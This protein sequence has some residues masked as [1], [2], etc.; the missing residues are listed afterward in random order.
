MDT[1]TPEGQEAE[2]PNYSLIASE[3]FGNDFKGEIKEQPANEQPAEPA[4]EPVEAE[5]EQPAE[6]VKESPVEAQEA[7]EEGETPISSFDE[8][9]ESQGWD[10]EWANSLEF[11]QKVDGETRLVTLKDLIATNQTLSAAEKRLEDAKEKAKTQYQQLAETQEKV[12]ETF[13]VAYAVLENQKKAIDEEAAKVD[14]ASLR[15]QDPGEASFKK[16]EF[17][18]RREAVEAEIGKLSTQYQEYVADQQQKSQAALQEH[19]QKEQ[20]ALLE[21]LPEWK[22]P[23]KAKAGHKEV[24]DYLSSQGFT[25]EEIAQASDH[26]LVIMARKAALYDKG[27]SAEPAKKKLVTVPKTLKPG[28]SVQAD[29]NKSKEDHYR[30]II[31]NNPNSRQAEEATVA[32]MQLRRGKP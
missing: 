17:K 5:E 25:P 12:E 6:V 32:L 24:A 8:L 2:A 30:K 11:E 19:L 16:Q 18:E 10:P 22:D 29:P 23:E 7:Q 27:A 20:E 4:Q 28:A 31:A 21:K 9:V 13:N 1:S 26:R 3:I 15:N 14:W